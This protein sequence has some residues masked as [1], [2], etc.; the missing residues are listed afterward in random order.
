MTGEDKVELKDKD[1]KRVLRTA[2]GRI[3]VSSGLGFREK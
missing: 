1:Y 2:M 3:R